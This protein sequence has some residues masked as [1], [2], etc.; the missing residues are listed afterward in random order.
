MKLISLISQIFNQFNDELN[1]DGQPP[2]H[3]I[4]LLALGL[5]LT[6]GRMPTVFK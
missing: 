3:L 6:R 1:A 2:G 4:K 5:R